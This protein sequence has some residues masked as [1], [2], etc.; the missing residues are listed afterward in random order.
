[1][2]TREFWQNRAKFPRAELAKYCGQWVA[3]SADGLRIV[4]SADTLEALE[5][6]IEKAGENAEQLMFEGVPAP[7]DDTHLGAEEVC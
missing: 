4:A 3:F 6:W 2:F 7:E 1:M 5:S